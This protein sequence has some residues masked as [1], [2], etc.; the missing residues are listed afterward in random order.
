L[1]GRFDDIEI[2]IKPDAWSDVDVILLHVTNTTV[3]EGQHVIGGMT[4]IAH[5]RRLS[6]LVP[7]LQL[8]TYSPDGGNHTHLQITKVPEPGQPWILG[9]DPPGMKRLSS[10]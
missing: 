5:V 4:P 6:S 9:Q 3:V 10:D 1:Y 2:D 8:R 7:G